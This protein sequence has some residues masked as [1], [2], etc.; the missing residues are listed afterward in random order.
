MNSYK[1]AWWIFLSF[2]FERQLYQ[3]AA[4]CLHENNYMRLEIRWLKL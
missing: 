2:S 3:T 1:I 4:S